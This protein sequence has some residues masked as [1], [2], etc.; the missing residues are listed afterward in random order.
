MKPRIPFRIGYQY[1]NWELDL[2]SIEDRIKDRNLYSSYLWVGSS[3]KKFLGFK[4]DR[5]ELIFHWDRLEIV[6]LEFNNKSKSYYDE[7]ND[8]LSQ[9]FPKFTSINHFN[10]GII[11]KYSTLKVNYWNVYYPDTN[12]IKVMYF[13]N[14]FPPKNLLVK[15]IQITQT[16]EELADM[17]NDLRK[18]CRELQ[19][20]KKTRNLSIA[21][22]M[23]LRESYERALALKFYLSNEGKVTNQFIS[24]YLYFLFKDIRYWK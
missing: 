12:E 15:P 3:M 5:T 6:I 13:S 23:K 21:E 8:A 18:E 14:S 4:P 9:R 22:K 24:F 20:L 17:F 16:F 11:F 1:E 7:L 10:G 2:I 19:I